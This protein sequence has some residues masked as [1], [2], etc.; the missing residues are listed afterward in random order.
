VKRLWLIAMTGALA[1]GACGS[2]TLGTPP[3]AS[4]VTFHLRNDG[5]STVYL[6][7]N[8]TIQYTIT[9][10]ADPV[11]E[12]ARTGTCACVCGQAS[13]PVCV[14]CFAGPRDVAGGAALDEHWSSVS[15]TTQA[16]PAGSCERRTPLPYG[17]YR[18]DV[19]VYPTVADALAGMY[20]RTAS[21]TFDLPGAGDAV[22]VQLGLSP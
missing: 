5:A 10:L 3:Q 22:D 8:C 11:H 19:P 15:V 7:E 2:S 21:Q 20:G 6:S 13:C 17:R 18:I 12:I 14:P 1:A 16:T 4:D 9:S